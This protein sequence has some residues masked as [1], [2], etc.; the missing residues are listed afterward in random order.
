M[1]SK[2]ET[3]FFLNKCGRIIIKCMLPINE[4]HVL[5]TGRNAYAT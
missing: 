1:S 4:L 2:P 3:D 5:M